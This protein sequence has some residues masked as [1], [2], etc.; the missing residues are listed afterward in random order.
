MIEW[1][2]VSSAF[3]WRSLSEGVAMND[4]TENPMNDLAD[5]AA[6]QIANQSHTQPPD[7]SKMISPWQRFLSV[8]GNP[9]VP[10]MLRA[11]GIIIGDAS[12]AV[13]V[14]CLV[15]IMLFFVAPVFYGLYRIAKGL[16]NG[17]KMAVYG[18]W[19]FWIEVAVI[20]LWASEWQAFGFAVA[21]VLFCL[22]PT[23]PAIRHWDKM[24]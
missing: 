12:L 9:Q 11:Y 7:S 2:I 6:P 10:T 1:L 21:V 17:E 5:N 8:P 14:L 23:I 4:A 16:Q 15:S 20:G 18:L 19:A 22:I 13:A 3:H 24:K